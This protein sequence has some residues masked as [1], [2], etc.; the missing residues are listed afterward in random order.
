[1][2][3]AGGGGTGKRTLLL[4]LLAL[5]PALLVA[6]LLV[7]QPSYGD[8]HLYA[9]LRLPVA[10]AALVLSAAAVAS[11]ALGPDRLRGA[12]LG[13]LAWAAVAALIAIGPFLEASPRARLYA[14]DARTGA[15]K[16]VNARAG[17]SPMVIAGHLYVTDPGDR[18]LVALD[19]ASGK[20]RWR[21]RLRPG[22]S[23]SRALPRDATLVA[24][25]ANG[26]VIVDATTG[27]T[28]AGSSACVPVDRG[29]VL[30][31]DGTS[32]YATT[33][34]Q[35]QD[36]GA[37]AGYRIGAD[38][39]TVFLVDRAKDFVR[40]VDARTGAERWRVSVRAAQL[41]VVLDSRIAVA[42]GTGGPLVVLDADTGQTVREISF[43]G[44]RIRATAGADDMIYVYTASPVAGGDQSG[45]VVA[46][47]AHTGALRWRSSLRSDE[48]PASGL[49][50]LGAYGGGVVVAGGPRV[51]DLDAADGAARWSVD[52]TELGQ[53]RRYALA[54]SSQRVTVA[55]GRVFLSTSASL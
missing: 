16:W 47:D 39:S 18:A 54:G 3:T 10:G 28:G 35:C 15:V 49:P 42:S 51:V 34:R 17:E 1:M 8:W 20:E 55:D 29:P 23:R 2:L 46:L 30:V 13:G 40:A 37:T 26:G 25:T 33:D 48:A 21:D 43:A 11:F 5:V 31:A 41:P 27:G 12:A 6:I 52:V 7:H 24:A 44:E 14:L 22:H 45:T 38:D 19:V 4:G 36:Q 32:A 53:S 50:A 9:T